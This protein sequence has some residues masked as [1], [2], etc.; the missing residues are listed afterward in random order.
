MVSYGKFIMC[1]ITTCFGY[2]IMVRFLVEEHSEL[3]TQESCTLAK[4]WHLN[5]SSSISLPW[6]AWKE[7][8]LDPGPHNIPPGYD[9]QDSTS[10]ITEEP[11]S[12][13]QIEAISDTLIPS[14]VQVDHHLRW[15]HEERQSSS[16]QNHTE[17]NLD[18]VMMDSPSGENHGVPSQSS[19]LIL[20]YVNLHISG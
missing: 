10:C 4:L 13:H 6:E 16:V 15:S 12:V 3:S 2:L 5:E 8:S 19:L 14:T 18:A 1:R 7:D 11:V 17:I 9:S 20:E